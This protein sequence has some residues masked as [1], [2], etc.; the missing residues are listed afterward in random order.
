MFQFAGAGIGLILVLWFLPGGLGSLL[1]RIRDAYLRS[2]RAATRA[3]SCRHSSPTRRDPEV[4][5][6]ARSAPAVAPVID[7]PAP[8]PTAHRRSSSTSAKRPI[9]DVDYFSY[10]DLALSGGTPNLLSLRSVDVAYGQVQVLFGVSLELRE[11]E[12]IALLGTNGAGKSTVLRAISGLVG[13]EARQHQPPGRRHQ[14]ARAAPRRR[15]RASSRCPAGKG[16]FPSLTVAENLRV[17]V[18]MHRRDR[19]WC[20]G[21][22]RAGARALP[23]LEE[24]PR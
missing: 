11:G 10:P 18:W 13:A 7:E 9:P 19:A 14:R 20:Q 16:V 6:G 4:L 17:G 21:S 23:R 1:Y 24:P 3:W 15:A 22:D 12:T 8:A 5:T 2:G